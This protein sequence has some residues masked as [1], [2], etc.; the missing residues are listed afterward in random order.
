MYGV[1]K[2]PTCA[3]SVANQQSVH[4]KPSINSWAAKGRNTKRPG[5]KVGAESQRSISTKLISITPEVEQNLNT[6]IKAWDTKKIANTLTQAGW[7]LD[8][9]VLEKTP[10]EMRASFT[11]GGR[12]HARTRGTLHFQD[13]QGNHIRIMQAKPNGQ[14]AQRVD[15]VKVGQGEDFYDWH[16]NLIKKSDVHPEP[17]NLEETHIPLEQWKKWQTWNKK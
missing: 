9:A 16:G 6:A 14:P 12:P 4:S 11:L 5:V 17:W 8:K 7:K 10:H 15:Y 13:S 3:A 1:G 2:K